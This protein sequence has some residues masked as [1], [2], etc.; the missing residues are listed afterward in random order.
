MGLLHR[1]RS[2]DR[3]AEQTDV[4][5]RR[6][7]AVDLRDGRPE[8]RSDDPT[9]VTSRDREG[10]PDGD[11]ATTPT[12]V[13]ERSWTFAPGQLVSMVVGG[14][15]VVLGTLALLRAGIS[16][17]LADPVV[18]VMG[19]D[20]TAWLGLG[21]IGLGLLLMLVGSGAWGRAISILLGATMVVAGVLVVAESGALPDELGLERS[22]GWL[23]VPLGAL[24][25]VAAMALPV[26]R[27][28]HTNVRTL[29][30]QQR[31]ERAERRRF[32]QRR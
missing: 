14:G 4:I 12:L 5:E 8:G 22:F 13:R 30:L 1:E 10:A 32:W 27:S 17:P 9:I 2:E 7:E 25:A 23:L 19:L 15:L 31:K 29:D 28:T 21:E 26:W 24:V 11:A 18:Q 6:D 20:H 3:T 16:E